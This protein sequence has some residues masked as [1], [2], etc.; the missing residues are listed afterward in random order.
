MSEFYLQL[1]E[2]VRKNLED[3]ESKLELVKQVLNEHFPEKHAVG[4]PRASG[5]GRYEADVQIDL[6]EL[7][8]SDFSFTVEWYQNE[9]SF[10]PHGTRLGGEKIL[11]SE[12]LEIDERIKEYVFVR[13]TGEDLEWDNDSFMEDGAVD[14]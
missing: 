4:S 7:S 12:A 10:S 2:P 11:M 6:S 1:K 14:Y 8:F 9:I 3:F 5:F 13:V